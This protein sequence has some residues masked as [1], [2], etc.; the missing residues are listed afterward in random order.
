[1]VLYCKEGGC[2]RSLKRSPL[3]TSA[4][5]SPREKN[6]SKTDHSTRLGFSLVTN[7]SRIFSI[8]PPNLS[9]MAPSDTAII[10]EIKNA[11]AT[12]YAD[13][14]TRDLLTVRRIRET[15]EP[16]LGLDVG[17]LSSEKWKDKS[18]KI[19]K[20]YAVGVPITLSSSN[21]NRFL[22]EPIDRETRSC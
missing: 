10:A 14:E 20:D 17:F 4:F 18:K 5:Q 15:V 19:I 11:I 1:M 16:K 2:G 7:Q 22:T 8:K 13:P 3:Q 12:V 9:T 21:S 6:T